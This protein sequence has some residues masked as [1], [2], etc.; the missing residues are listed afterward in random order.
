MGIFRGACFLY[1]AAS[2][3][4]LLNSPKCRI[5]TEHM[6]GSFNSFVLK[7]QLSNS[8][9]LALLTLLHEHNQTRVAGR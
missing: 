8:D 9:H 4:L 1:R 3:I 5:T 7:G 2:R 6:N